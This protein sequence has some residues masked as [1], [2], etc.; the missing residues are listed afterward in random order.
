MAWWNK[1]VWS[2]WSYMQL[3]NWFFLVKRCKSVATNQLLRSGNYVKKEGYAY[4]ATWA[5][6][7]HTRTW[8]ILLI[9]SHFFKEKP[10]PIRNWLKKDIK[11]VYI[12]TWMR[13]TCQPRINTDSID[14]SIS[15]YT[16]LWKEIFLIYHPHT[17]CLKSHFQNIRGHPLSMKMEMDQKV[18]SKGLTVRR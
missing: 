8:K 15:Q 12:S 16:I 17:S 11:D 6:I 9:I 14:N 10:Y 1:K 13:P 7:S 18:N 4:I 5:M 3:I 2:L